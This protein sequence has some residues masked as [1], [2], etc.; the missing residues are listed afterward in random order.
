MRSEPP[1]WLE[2]FISV[3]QQ[4]DIHNLDKL[5]QIY[6]ADI[7]FEDPLH[8]IDGL[9]SLTRYFSQL[10]Q[11]VVFCDFTIEHSIHGENEVALY[12]QM[13]YAHPSLNKGRAIEVAGHSHLQAT[14]GKIH[15]HRD[16]FDTSTMLYEHV[17]LLGATVRLIKRRVS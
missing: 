12:W 14:D 11:N 4:L 1:P 6:H 2:Q 17:P 5:A 15:Y 10:Y 16:Y 9:T 13:R 7:H 8:R 3:Y